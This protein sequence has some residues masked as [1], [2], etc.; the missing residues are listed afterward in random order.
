MSKE[1]DQEKF[2]LEHALEHGIDFNTRTIRITGEIGENFDFDLL[3]YALTELESRNE[4]GILIRIN[5]PGGSCYEAQAFIGRMKA[6]PCLITVQAFGYCMSAATL[7]LM[8]ADVREM[9]R[10]CTPMFHK[11]SFGFR[12]TLD[13]NEEYTAQAK[14]EQLQWAKWYEEFSDKPSSF[15]MKKM[16]KTEFYPSP[17]QLLEF[18]A[19]DK[20]I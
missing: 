3:D 1:I 7:I 18:G 9:S 6:S 15:W 11:M 12:G 20:V 8:A 4:E 19:I 14:K 13:E 10:F 17:E 2:K 16:K 5:S